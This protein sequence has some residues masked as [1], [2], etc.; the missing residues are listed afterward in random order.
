[1]AKNRL[2]RLLDTILVPA[3]AMISGLI[4]MGILIILIKKPLFEA[5]AI[6]FST[7]FGCERYG[8]CILSLRL[9]VPRL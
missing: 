1:M 7:G 5:Y 8:D 2:L 6:L 4:V 3:L 9:S